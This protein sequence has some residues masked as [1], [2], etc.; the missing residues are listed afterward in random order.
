[1]A[2]LERVVLKYSDTEELEDFQ[3]GLEPGS[4]VAG[5]SLKPGELMI[6]RGE[7]F[8]EI[9]TLDR[10]ST[11]RRITMDIGGTIPPWQTSE[12]A[13]A[14]IDQLGDVDLSDGLPSAQGGEIGLDQA[15]WVLTWDGLKWVVRPQAQS[16]GY[17]GA[18]PSLN[19]VGDVDYG[20]YANALNP[21]FVPD[22]GDVLR[23]RFDNIQQLYFWAPENLALSSLDDVLTGNG[24]V[25]FN[26]ALYQRLQFGPPTSGVAAGNYAGI[27]AVDADNQSIQISGAGSDP[28]RLTVSKGFGATSRLEIYEDF[29][30]EGKHYSVDGVAYVTR[31]ALEYAEE[32][33]KFELDNEFQIPSLKHVREDFQNRSISELSDVE[34]A[35]VQEGYVLIWDS[36]NGRWSPG[37][38]PAPDLTNASINELADVNTTLIDKDRKPLVYDA[39]TAKWLPSNLRLFDQIFDYMSD[40]FYLGTDPDNFTTRAKVC[41]EENLGRI[42]VVNNIP[43]VCLRCR[44]SAGRVTVGD[45]PSGLV[46]N[47][48]GYVRLL[49]HGNTTTADQGTHPPAENRPR[50]EPFIGRTDPL[51]AVAYGGS[52]GDLENVS[53]ADV[54]QGSSLVW[55]QADLKFVQGFPALDLTTY[56]I[57]ELSDVQPQGAGTGYG[58]LWNGSAWV[59][60]SLDQKFRLDDMQDVQFGD[61]GVTNNKLVA[62]YM[63]IEN[64]ATPP[65]EAG[66]DVSTLLAVSTPKGDAQLGST[67][68]FSSP[69]GQFYSVARYFGTESNWGINQKLDNYVRWPNEPSWQ[70][71]DG[72]GCIELFFYCPLLLQDRT[73]FR[74]NGTPGN[75]SYTLTLRE[76]GGLSFNAV[77]PGGS[78][79]VTMTTPNN[80]VSLN[81]WH[82]VAISKEQTT[83][84]LYLDG[85]LVD[86]DT[87]LVTYTGNEEFVLGRNDLDDNNPLTHY[88]FVGYMLDLRVTRGRAKYTDNTI[89][90]PV[91]IGAEILDTTPNA[92]DFLSYDGSK[93]T[94]VQGVNADI[95]GNVIGELLDV[96]TT[97]NNAITGDALVW[98]GSRWEPGIPGV[99]AAWGLDDFTDVST[100]YQVGTPYVRLD[101]ARMLTFSRLGEVPDDLAYLQQVDGNSIIL[102]KYDYSYTCNPNI[103]GNN[104]PYSNGTTTYV[105]VGNQGQVSIAAERITIQNVF[106]DCFVIPRRYH[107]DTLHYADCPDRNGSTADGG[108]IP[109]D[110]PDTYIPCWG[111]IEDHINEALAYGNVGALSDVSAVAPTLGQALAW[112]GSQWAPSSSIAADISN[113]SISD[114]ADVDTS[115]GIAAG[116]VLTWDGSMWR[117]AVPLDSIF[118]FQDVDLIGITNNFPISEN[119]IFGATPPQSQT[120]GPAPGDTHANGLLDISGL[121]GIRL[122]TYDTTPGA[123]SPSYAYIWGGV[124]P[125]APLYLSSGGSRIEIGREVIRIADSGNAAAGTLGFRLAEGWFFTYE[126]ATI[127]WA[128]FTGMQVP[129]KL[130]IQTYVDTGLANL[131]LSPNS[132][133]DLGNVDTSGKAQG[134]TIKWDGAQWIS[135][136]SVAADISNSSIGDLTDVVKVDNAGPGINDGSV[137]LDVGLLLTS[138]PREAG[139]GV[140]L[141]SSNGIGL[142]GWSDTNEGA[143]YLENTSGTIGTSSIS[144]D[145]DQIS[146]AGNA[147]VVMQ[148][149]PALGDNT[150]P[151]WVQ[152]RQQ[153]A[154]EAVDYKALFLLDFDDFRESVYNWPLDNQVVSAPNPVLDSPHPGKFSAYFRRGSNDKLQWLATDGCPETWAA[155]GLWSLEFFIRVDSSVTNP[156]GNKEFIVSEVGSASYFSNG[157]HLFLSGAQRNK[158][159]LNIG[160]VDSRNGTAGQLQ[161]DLPFDQWAHVYVAN[162]GGYNVRLYIDGQLIGTHVQNASWQWQN[163]LAIGGKEQPNAGDV[164][165]YGTFQLDD[166]RITRDWLPY[167]ADAGSVPVPVDPLPEGS[168]PF[169]F[170]KITSL[171]DVNTLANP[172]INGD[173]LIWDA[174]NGYW[175]P[176]AAPAADISASSIGLLSDVTTDNSVPDDNDILAWSAADGD[177]RRTKVDGNGGVTPRF[178]RTVTP[179]VVPSVGT[180]LSGSLFLNMADRKMFALDATGQPFEFATGEVLATVTEI[181][182]GEF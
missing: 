18:I 116:N 9:W 146:V 118:D 30:I 152:V 11:P 24:L 155:L 69:D 35:G 97:T 87:G 40:G 68:E 41:N 28:D 49:I 32:H 99:G 122:R 126:D 93:W 163:G 114:L 164:S 52:L 51:S 100:E 75:G 37:T 120:F 91:S 22:E 140:Q 47:R 149:L 96:D 86:T 154:L 3:R 162:E 27:G 128:T 109:G 72:D 19:D 141:N 33:H 117:P 4:G 105:A 181:R 180:L 139:G 174:V 76:E 178:A 85:Q 161:G 157:L 78:G 6:R 132:L 131:D 64:T 151:T 67:R 82:H 21:K 15:G 81:N 70:T 83:H 79:G 135:S 113:N 46:N 124:S 29:L 61:L 77:G 182:G 104:G 112:N 150:L 65:Y 123:S 106:Y 34:V 90:I 130:S 59:A 153:I 73:I 74:K 144:V 121:R 62:A 58:L 43:Y 102:G 129:N 127:D 148:S 175:A 119:D 171:S 101:Q 111:V 89:T 26:T 66:D 10:D 13:N 38:G 179:G 56:S 176:G 142:I 95:S 143:P 7:D 94:N 159:N 53:T 110:V 172:P 136:A 50:I 133:D 44:S 115:Q 16:Q 31:V 23:Y 42:T 17:E 167:P 2:N 98:T 168:A 25:Q 88:F 170:G 57:G 137:S 80:S 177:F 165:S 5:G 8:A 92:G 156:E 158:L 166:F 45:D 1:M 134:Y 108:D 84:R 39:A 14:S 169:V 160:S 48:Y 54:F 138:R 12:L 36:V 147:G 20:F 103:P 145:P 71:L 63:L 107:E 55:S 60:S 125:Y 173:A